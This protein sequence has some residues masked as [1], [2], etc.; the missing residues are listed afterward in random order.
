MKLTC[1]LASVVQ[2]AF[3]LQVP[4]APALGPDST[5]NMTSTPTC[6]VPSRSVRVAVTVWSA[7]TGFVAMTGVRAILTTVIPQGRAS[8]GVGLNGA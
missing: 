3:A 5:V 1:P 8:G 7:P 6:G 2:S 4:L